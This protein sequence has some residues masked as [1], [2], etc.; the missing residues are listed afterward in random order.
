MLLDACN[1]MITAAQAGHP[2]LGIITHLNFSGAFEHHQFEHHY[3]SK[4]L[5]LKC[6]TV[7]ADEQLSKCQ[8]KATSLLLA[9]FTH[10]TTVLMR[11]EEHFLLP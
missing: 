3:P 9:Q 10:N 7:L 6:T 2:F 4:F 8:K 5:F 1:T 11:R